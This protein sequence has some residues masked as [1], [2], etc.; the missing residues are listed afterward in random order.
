[1]SVPEIDFQSP[2]LV[3]GPLLKRGLFIPFPEA[4][5]TAASSTYLIGYAWV[6]Y[7]LTFIIKFR[8][9]CSTNLS[10]RAIFRTFALQLTE[11]PQ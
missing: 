4:L 8:C 10:K 3:T 1:M 9:Y 5:S 7:S 2:T 6:R 11:K